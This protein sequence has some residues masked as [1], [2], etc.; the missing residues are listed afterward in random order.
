MNKSK[1]DK[2]VSRLEKFPN[3]TILSDEIYSK[4]IFDKN[5]MPSLLQYKSIRNRLIILDGWS[6]TFCMT[7][8]RLGWS[9]WPKNLIEYANK[10]CVNDHSCP[11][12]VSQYAGIEALKG[13]Q[14]EINK[15][16]SKFQKRRDFFF[17][18]SSNHGYSLRK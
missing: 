4:I 9:V 13:S 2:L 17:N 6:K 1:I 10:L 3:I 11:T 8:W 16:I 5:A 12:T 14:E 7:G 18:R 15:I